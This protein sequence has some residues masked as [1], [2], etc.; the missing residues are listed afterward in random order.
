LRIIAKDFN[1]FHAIPSPEENILQRVRNRTPSREGRRPA[2]LRSGSRTSSNGSLR[3]DRSLHSE[4]NA[5]NPSTSRVTSW[6]TTSTGDTL[7]Q[8]AMKRLTVIHEAK[9]SIGS[10]ADRIASMSMKR[11]SLP[12]GAIGA[13]AAFRDPMPME[14][15]LEDSSIPVDPKRV[16]SALMKEIETSKLAEVTVEP[17]HRT[18]GAESDVFESSKTKSLHT[19]GRE[20]HTS[21]SRD[22]RPSTATEQRP[23]SRRPPSAAAH[24]TK[25]KT[26]SIRS[27]GRAIR[28]T[29]RT[30]TPGEYRSSPIYESHIPREDAE[31][32][33]SSPTSEREDCIT[34]DTGY[35][36]GII[37][38]ICSSS[39]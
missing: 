39:Y 9:D 5:S 11:K 38:N 3:S 27:L 20:L 4:A 17:I 22:F 16:F 21:A 19:S 33:S 31:M 13:L 2:Y 14:S 37:L 36:F 30:V 29:I 12:A 1:L 18:P 24:S 15:L 35:V 26:S 25:S 34:L 23:P 28:S 6:G 8:R 10:E 7:T 32:P